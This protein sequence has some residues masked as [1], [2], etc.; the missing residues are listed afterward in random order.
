MF[1]VFCFNFQIKVIQDLPVGEN[2]QDHLNVVN[3][4]WISNG[5][6]TVTKKQSESLISLLNYFILGKG[7]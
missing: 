4:H 5:S 2:L 3:L 1:I 7:T 6:L